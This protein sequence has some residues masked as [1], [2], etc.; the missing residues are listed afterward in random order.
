MT[1]DKLEEKIAEFTGWPTEAWKNHRL[2]ILTDDR[3][4]LEEREIQDG[5]DTKDED[6][7]NV[8][9]LLDQIV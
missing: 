2:F 3:D 1:L 6:Y 8:L 5:I 9:D 4:G 7:E